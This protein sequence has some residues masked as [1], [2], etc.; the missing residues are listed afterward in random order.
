MKAVA[1]A[2][3]WA[4]NAL[5]PDFGAAG[6][7]IRAA[8]AAT[9]DVAERLPNWYSSKQGLTEESPAVFGTAGMGL[10]HA[11]GALVDGRDP[12]ADV[13]FAACA[14]EPIELD[15]D[16]HDVADAFLANDPHAAAE[17]FYAVAAS[18]Y[19]Y[20][21]LLSRED[22]ADTY[23]GAG[24]TIARAASALRDAANALR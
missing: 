21:E 11:G 8:G 20:T 1:F 4:A 13:T 24:A 6:E 7:A 17:S 19:V 9:S 16:L 14:L 18:F 5:S 2:L 12:A 3:P 15:T 23:E 10:T 22:H